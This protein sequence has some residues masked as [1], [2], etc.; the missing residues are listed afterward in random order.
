[1]FMRTI[2]WKLDEFS[3]ILILRNKLWFQNAVEQISN[4]WET[5]KRERETGYEHRAPKK[6][7]RKNSINSDDDNKCHILLSDKI[8][9][10]L[11]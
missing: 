4:T 11:L 5:I 8:K 3:C 1:M 7:E 2:Y 10:Q 6:R 9:T